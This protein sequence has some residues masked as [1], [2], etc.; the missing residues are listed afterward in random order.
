MADLSDSANWFEVDGS[1]N[2][3]PP[4]GW[5]EGMMPSGVNDTARA[6]KGALKRFWDKL[7]PV[8]GV[9][10]SGGVYTFTT[11]NPA[12]PAGYVVG[13]IYHFGPGSDAAGGEQFQVNTL[14]AK[15]IYKRIFNAP[16][17]APIAAHDMVGSFPAT[18]VYN[19][20]L[21]AGSGG[22]VLLNPYVPISGD[23]GGGITLPGNIT[24]GGSFTASGDLHAGGWLYLNGTAILFDGNPNF[25]QGPYINFDQTNFTGRLGSANGAYNF[26]NSAGTS[27]LQIFGN[28]QVQAPAGS[29]WTR[30]GAAGF[31]FDDQ[32]TG[33]T[34]VL[35]ANNGQ[36]NLNNGANIITVNDASGDVGFFHNVN[37]AVDVHVGGTLYTAGISDSGG[38]IFGGDLHCGNLIASAGL[39][40]DNGVPGAQGPSFV[41]TGTDIYCKIPPGDGRLNLQ[42]NNG[43]SNIWFEPRT[44]NIGA[45]GVINAGSI[46]AAGAISAGNFITSTGAGGGFQF[47]DQVTGKS[48]VLYANNGQ[49]NLNNGANIITVNDASGDVG[50]FHN[51][52]VAV[53][54]HV[55][56]TLYTAGISD[57]GGAVFG[58]D[59]HCGN[60]QCSNNISAGSEVYAGNMF[61]H[62]GGAGALVETW[63]GDWAGMSFAMSGG[64]LLVSADRGTS[65]FVL[66][67]SSG[68]SDARLKTDIRNTKVDALAAICATPIR[69]FK[70]NRE[71]RKLM[72]HAEPAVACGLVAQEIEELIPG[73]V[74][75]APLAG[76][77]RHI[78]DPYLTPWVFRAI[79]QL[80]ARITQ[81]EDK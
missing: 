44:G 13:E 38:A 17:W 65:G 7:N 3:P 41:G 64:N 80:E 23:G 70:W 26:L 28:G 5:P 55:G 50:F 11:S 68:F 45:T 19:A 47:H 73:S 56:G 15:P 20:T 33:K 52:N 27:V 14:G 67:P 25:S 60:V 46:S 66:T 4:N 32:V 24:I 54:V 8:Q 69:A 79:Q 71:G 49:V 48:W 58:G 2:R 53:D 16:Y 6:D 22:F 10:S 9:T 63:G 29:F 75:S 31:E 36:V 42:A 61:R 57:S 62:S 18:L 21:N 1:N 43:N 77:M 39:Y 34:W 78:N 76:D 74:G 40:F 81:L 51:V 59:L 37:V 30:G 35:Y 72:P 12:Y